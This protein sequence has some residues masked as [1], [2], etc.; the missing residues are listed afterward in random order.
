MVFNLWLL[1]G[2][3]FQIYSNMFFYF[4]PENLGK[5]NPFWR[6]YFFKGVG[7]KPP[8]RKKNQLPGDSSRALLI[9]DRWRSLK[10]SPWKGHLTHHPK[11]VQ[12]P[13]SSPHG[14]NESSPGA[15]QWK[16]SKFSFRWKL[17]EICLGRVP[18]PRRGP[19]LFNARGVPWLVVDG[20]NGATF[21]PRLGFWGRQRLLEKLC[22]F[23]VFFVFCWGFS[24]NK[25]RWMFCWQDG[26]YI[27]T[28]IFVYNI[29]MV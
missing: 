11:E 26:V 27:Y 25:N 7:L 15:P 19:C 22:F 9:P 6:A 28:Y 12:P 21:S 10:L 20:P 23:T 8:T 18:G 14:R 2:W 4:H 13:T 3:W 1:T 16:P 29:K 24:D 17:T 5:M